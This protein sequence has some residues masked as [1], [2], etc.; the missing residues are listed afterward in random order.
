MGSVKTAYYSPTQKVTLL[1]L[2]TPFIEELPH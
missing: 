2:A 1:A